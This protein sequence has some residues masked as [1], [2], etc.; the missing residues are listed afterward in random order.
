MKKEKG[1]VGAGFYVSLTKY[2]HLKAESYAPLTYVNARL[3]CKKC[4]TKIFISAMGQPSSFP[5]R[6]GSKLVSKCKLNLNS[7][8]ENKKDQVG[9]YKNDTGIYGN[10]DL[11]RKEGSNP[12]IDPQF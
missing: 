6:T 12:F 9:L 11:A 1:H 2:L 4:P 8:G 3:E 5:F 7:F 10:D